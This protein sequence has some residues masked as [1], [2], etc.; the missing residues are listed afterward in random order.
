M[1]TSPSSFSR[2]THQP[3]GSAIAEGDWLSLTSENVERLGAAWS[4]G[5]PGD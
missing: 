5:D 2:T 4:P 3:G 1:R